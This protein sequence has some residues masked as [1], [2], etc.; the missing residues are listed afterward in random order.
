METYKG[1]A[2]W[3]AIEWTTEKSAHEFRRPFILRAIE[4]W[5]KRKDENQVSFFKEALAHLDKKLGV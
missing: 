2:L 1:S 4:N 5:E 3:N